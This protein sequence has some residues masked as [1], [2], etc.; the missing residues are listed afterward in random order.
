MA[1]IQ[2]RQIQHIRLSTPP[3]AFETEVVWLYQRYNPKKLKKDP[4]KTS[5]HTLP[6]NLLDSIIQILNI[7]H[8]YFSSP[9]TCFT[10]TKN[11]YSPFARD[12]FFGSLGTAFQYKWKGIE[13]AHPHNEEMT[14]QAVHWARLAAK[15]DPNT[16]TLLTIPD[17]NWYQNYAPHTGPFPDTHVLAHFTADSVTY[18]EPTNPQSTIKPRT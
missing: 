17:I 10:L 8:S 9:T 7:S 15:N 1:T 14:Q 13:Y 4:L 2:H 18:D 16:I 6:Q 3:Q 5:Q 12:K 11:F